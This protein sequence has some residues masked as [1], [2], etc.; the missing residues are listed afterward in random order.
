MAH[1]A[2]T[3]I[4]IVVTRAVTDST[5]A[6]C[7][8]QNIESKRNIHSNNKP[9]STLRRIRKQKTVWARA[10][11]ARFQHRV[12]TGNKCMVFRIYIYSFCTLLGRHI[13][14]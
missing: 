10:K 3:G 7:L 9:Y 8:T 14:I 11:D 4:H 5:E 2:K 12:Y 13:C 1:L 6:M